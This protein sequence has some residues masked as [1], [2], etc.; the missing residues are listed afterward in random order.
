M[1]FSSVSNKQMS[2]W[3]TDV[4]K[5][6]SS[7]NTC[8]DKCS[9]GSNECVDFGWFTSQDLQV[10][11]SVLWTRASNFHHKVTENSNM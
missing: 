9:V 6:L 10:C 5:V 3:L 4:S 7:P 8:E 2:T 11:V 1:I